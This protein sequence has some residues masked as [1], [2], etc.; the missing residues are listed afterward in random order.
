VAR[1]A[2][3]ESPREVEAP[4]IEGENK[5]VATTVEGG[6]NVAAVSSSGEAS[7]GAGPADGSRAGVFG[8]GTEALKKLTE[9]AARAGGEREDLPVD[10][11]IPPGILDLVLDLLALHGTGEGGIPVQRFWDDLRTCLEEAAHEGHLDDIAAFLADPV[12]VAELLRE[13]GLR[14]SGNEVTDEELLGALEDELASPDAG[15]DVV[16]SEAGKN[17]APDSEMGE[18]AASDAGKNEAPDVEMG[19]AAAS[20][21]GKDEAVARAPWSTHSCH[22]HPNLPNPTRCYPTR[23]PCRPYPTLP[24]LTRPTRPCRPRP[25]P[26]DPAG[27][28]RPYRPRRAGEFEEGRVRSG[29]VG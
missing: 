10:D 26:A 21:A 24:D 23:R 9:I 12:Y 15:A 20:D 17:E 29:K 1:S 22:I 16:A 19:E 3:I 2:A 14:P 5:D 8:S 11:G 27:L 13:L 4:E 28:T 18:A 6:E 7:G 25:G